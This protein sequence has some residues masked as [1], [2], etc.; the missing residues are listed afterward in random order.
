MY[1]ENDFA[2][3]TSIVF[4]EG[5]KDEY[6]KTYSGIISY[7]SRTSIGLSK[8]VVHYIWKNSNTTNSMCHNFSI[9]KIS[10]KQ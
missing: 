5:K 6:Y 1:K 2:L 10:I 8:A 4:N 9:D 7:E 3:I